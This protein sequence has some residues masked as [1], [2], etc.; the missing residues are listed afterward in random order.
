MPNILSN[1][2]QNQRQA[3]TTVDIPLLIVAGPGSGKTRVITHKIA[4]LVKHHSIPL[5]QILAVT[6]TNKAARE[7]LL[8]T[9]HLLNTNTFPKETWITTFHA[10][11]YKI[12]K[13]H[14]NTLGFSAPPTVIDQEDALE[15]V[16][17]ILDELRI[18]K[19]ERPTAQKVHHYIRKIK[20]YLL[21]PEKVI[22]N[23][24]DDPELKDVDEKIV[25]T[26]MKILPPVYYKYQERLK[27]LKYVDFDDLIIMPIK[28]FKNH[29][30]IKDYYRKYFAYILVDE[31]QDTNP[32]QYELLKA[33]SLGR[34]EVSVVGDDDQSIYSWRNATP[35]NMFKFREDFNPKVVNLDITYRLPRNILAAASILM[36]KAPKRFPKSLT[37]IKKYNGEVFYVRLYDSRD[38]ARFVATTIKNLVS[39]GYKYSD[40][41]IFYRLHRLSRPIEQLLTNYKIPYVIYSGVSFFERKEIKDILAVLRVLVN[42][43][44]EISFKRL[45]MMMPNL[46]EKTFKSIVEIA[47]ERNVSL[48]KAA[49][50]LL[51]AV[52]A[53]RKISL[54]LLINT[55]KAIRGA[56]KHKVKNNPSELP[57]L[58]KYIMKKFNYIDLLKRQYESE[59]LYQR[60]ENLKELVSFVTEY[61]STD[62][63]PTLKGF[64]SQLALSTET[65]A[66]ENEDTVKL[67]TLHSAK[68]LE[69]KVVF[70]IHAVDGVIPFKKAEDFEEER[71]L[72]YVGITR[73]ADVCY[74]SSPMYETT[75][76]KWTKVLENSPFLE[77][78]LDYIT[79]IEEEII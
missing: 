50:L 42:P 35:E 75:R 78:I 66:D 28:L 31:F 59:E 46:G 53:K 15:L 61:A 27:N 48:V 54:N 2:N 7:M 64:L 60:M 3:V 16:N 62:P 30:E 11:G 39:Q 18:P 33:I 76:Y 72:F 23:L 36:L 26:L 12:I 56:Y 69:F 5:D 44:D 17:L 67:M 6:F 32:A 38:E 22:S 4:Y 79:T 77:D 52:S 57:N 34:N 21:P 10:M 25:S 65:M 68:G 55:L 20:E 29:P 19:D 58:I 45:V 9:A 73:S 47:K 71:R 13:K 24:K 8:R 63:N 40:I 49:K 74:I 14:F 37:T 1:L 41:A 43:R 70:I 51:P